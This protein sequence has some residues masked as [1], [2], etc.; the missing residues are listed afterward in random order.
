[1][2]WSVVHHKARCVRATS[3]PASMRGEAATAGS[4]LTVVEVVVKADICRNEVIVDDFFSLGMVHLPPLAL[5]LLLHCLCLKNYGAGHR[6]QGLE[7][8][9]ECTVD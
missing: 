2:R 4:S 7:V 3:T 9:L 6:V 5:M 1:M 8:V